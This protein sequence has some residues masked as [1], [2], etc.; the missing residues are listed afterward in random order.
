MALLK[1][2][3]WFTLNFKLLAEGGE[4]LLKCRAMNSELVTPKGEVFQTGDS[5]NFSNK[6]ETL[7]KL[8]HD[9]RF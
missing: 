1:R 8:S 4:Y 5:L 3:G 6:A 7:T 2:F 9:S